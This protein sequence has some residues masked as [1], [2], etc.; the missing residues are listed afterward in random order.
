VTVIVDSV[1][2]MGIRWTPAHI[3]KEIR[4]RLQPTVTD[5]NAS[6][7]VAAESRIIGI[8]AAVFHQRPTI[9]FDGRSLAVLGGAFLNQF[10]HHATAGTRGA[11]AEA[12]QDDRSHCSAVASTN[13]VAL[14]ISNGLMEHEKSTEALTSRIM[15]HAVIIPNNVT[16]QKPKA[17]Q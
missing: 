9:V 3:V 1:K 8:K 13:S 6:T 2:R 4:E 16:L 17:H 11:S 10:S 12:P 15:N 14:F 7:A 5:R